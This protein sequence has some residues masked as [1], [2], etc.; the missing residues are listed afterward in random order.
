MILDW[1]KC[2]E[3]IWDFRKTSGFVDYIDPRID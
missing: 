1:G 2:D 3:G